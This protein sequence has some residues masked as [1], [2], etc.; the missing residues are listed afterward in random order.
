LT[1]PKLS[2]ER[3]DAVESTLKNNEPLWKKASNTF[4]IM[5]NAQ[6]GEKYGPFHAKPLTIRSL[7]VLAERCLPVHNFE[8]GIKFKQQNI[9]ANIPQISKR[10]STDLPHHRVAE[11]F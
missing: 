11:Y 1:P 9:A 2:R 7:S 5:V 8:T 3:P 10:K 6:V 4:E